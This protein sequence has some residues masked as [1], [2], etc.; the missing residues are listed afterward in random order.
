MQHG[1]YYPPAPEH[2]EKTFGIELPPIL[3]FSFD[4][5]CRPQGEALSF[6]HL[7]FGDRLQ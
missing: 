2:Y 6:C 3:T 4:F 5:A 7:S 1:K